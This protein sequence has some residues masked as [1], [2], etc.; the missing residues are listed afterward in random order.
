MEKL[1]ISVAMEEA[2]WRRK[3][4]T[5]QRSIKMGKTKTMRTKVQIDLAK[6]AIERRNDKSRNAMHR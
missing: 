3:A 5:K 6:T 4:T 1:L 2:S